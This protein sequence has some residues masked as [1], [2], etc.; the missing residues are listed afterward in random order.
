MTPAPA[1]PRHPPRTGGTR[2]RLLRSILASLYDKG[3]VTLVQILSIPALGAAWGADGYGVWLVLMAVPTAIALSD[4]G[5]GAAAGVEMTRLLA[6]GEE[7][8][9]APVLHSTIVFVAGMLAGAAALALLLAG[10]LWLRGQPVGPFGAGETA[11]AIA[12]VAGQALAMGQTGIATAVWRATH[13][14]AFAMGFSGTLLLLEGVAPVLVALAGGRIALA[15]GAVLVLRLAGLALFLRLLRRRAPWAAFGI[16]H[17]R[18]GTIRALARPALAAFG[19]TAA[20]ALSL[21]GMVLALGAVAG[22]GAVAVFGAART[23]CRAP[24]QLAGMVVRPS[25]P[26][27]TR[28][29]SGGDTALARRLAR[30]N[31]AVAVAV[32]LPSGLLLALL[33]GR[34]VRAISGGTLEATAPLLALLALGAG[35]NAVWT[36]QAAPL[37]ALN[38]QGAFAPAYLLGVLAALGAVAVLA[39][40]GRADAPTIAALCGALP[41]FALLLLLGRRARALPEP[42][43]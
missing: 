32:M 13:G 6:R 30:L 25:I 43:P 24:L 35:A 37:V 17:A 28:A 3:A 18:R 1:L 14:Y 12:L 20:T 34:I 41:E 23:V 16:R 19:L 9:A 31:V 40:G 2:G 39:G 27:L 8:E 36:A 11:L 38:R 5:F 22:P 15:A 7:H 42:A 33:G 29:L 26:E 10:W 21:Q 4:L